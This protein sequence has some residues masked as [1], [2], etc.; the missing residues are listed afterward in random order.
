[1]SETDKVFTGS[2]AENYDRYLVPLIFESFAQDVA[3]RVAGS[4]PVRSWKPL[5]AVASSPGHWPHCFPGM[6]AM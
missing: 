1:M 4:R 6:P 3:R 5:P 2:I